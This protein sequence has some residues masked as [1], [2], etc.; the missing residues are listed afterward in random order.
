MNRALELYE[1]CRPIKSA[2]NKAAKKGLIQGNNYHELV[3]SAIKEGIV[4][5]DQALQLTEYIKI[6][7]DIINVDDFSQE[8]IDQIR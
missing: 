6:A 1:V 5:K 8:E 3:D 2:I 4:S 7:E